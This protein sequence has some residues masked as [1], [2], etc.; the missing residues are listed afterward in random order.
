[1][2][3]NEP[4]GSML[5]EE[6]QTFPKWLSLVLLSP[7]L[8]TIGLTLAIGSSTGS[9]RQEMI[10][11]L[12][13]VIPVNVLSFFLMYATRFEKVVTLDGFFYRWTPLQKKYRW[14]RREEIRSME[15]RP[16]P[17]HKLGYNYSF[18]HGYVHTMSSGKGWQVHLTNGKR[19]FFGTAD[20]FLFE[21][22]IQ[23]FYS[24]P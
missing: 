17:A 3:V 16:A 18:R 13:I 20:P 5:F 15:F 24:K 4:T 7:V 9:E 1:M 8:L 21:R 22:A 11:A 14:I 19:M 6:K 10:L 23:E 2:K 12:A